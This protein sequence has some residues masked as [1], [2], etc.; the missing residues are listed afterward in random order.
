MT[1]KVRSSVLE[2]TAVTAGTYG[3][4]SNNA[5]FTVDEL[6]SLLGIK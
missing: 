5:V 2:N 1:T 4:T 3:G 6:K